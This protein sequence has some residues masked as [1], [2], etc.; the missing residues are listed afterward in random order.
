MHLHAPVDADDADAV[1]SDCADGTGH[2]CTV[3]VLVSRVGI[4]AGEVI[5][6]DVVDVAV[7]VI[8]DPVAGDFARVLPQV[9][10]Q[11]RVR[12][13]DARVSH[14]DDHVT[15]GGQVPGLLGCDRSHPPQQSV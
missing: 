6:V 5:A 1:V 12:Q 3:A 15:T 10:P 8:V 13:V 2:V 9:V 11:I 4:V 7:A 14:R